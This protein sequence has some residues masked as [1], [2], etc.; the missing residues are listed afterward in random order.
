MRVFVCIPCL[1]TG[2]TESQTLSLVKTLVAAGLTLTVVCYKYYDNE[3]SP[4]T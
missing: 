1:N 3:Y 2:E 4:R